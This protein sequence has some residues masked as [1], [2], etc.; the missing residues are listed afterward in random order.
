MGDADPKSLAAI[1]LAGL[2]A[3][4]VNTLAGGG[5]LLTLPA[6]MLLG[7]PADVANGT[8][9]IGVLLQSL[10]ATKDFDREEQLPR[11]ALPMLALPTVTGAIGGAWLASVLRREV[12]TPVVIVLL[13]LVAITLVWKPKVVTVAPGEMPRTLREKPLAGLALFVLGIYAGFLQAGMG[14]FALLLFGGALRY[15]LVKGNAIKVALVALLS[16]AALTVFVLN[17]K[18]VWLPGIFLAVFTMA[19]AKLGVRFATRVDANVLRKVVF[20]AVLVCLAA[21][22]Y[23]EFG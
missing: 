2:I 12:F 8:N 1:A 22:V 10:V 16:I 9:R 21:A 6:L 18:V 19:G 4:V 5:S 17:D 23:K 15:D 14:L 7:L 13:A 3:G 20:V 11:A